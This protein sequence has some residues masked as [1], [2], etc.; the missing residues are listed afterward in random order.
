MSDVKP[1]VVTAEVLHR[2]WSRLEGARGAYALGDGVSF[3]TF[4]R[5][6]TGS[7]LVYEFPFGLIRYVLI[8]EE[9]MEIHPVLWSSSYMRPSGRKQMLA[10][11]MDA[12]RRLKATRARALP[13]ANSRSMRRLALRFGLEDMG[14]EKLRPFSG[15]QIRCRLY[16]R[17]IQ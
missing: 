16:E 7:P 15:I 11:L 1:A 8:G 5:E 3:E 9:L 2:W 12:A 14:F 17:S 4:A 6:Y 10:S 13:P